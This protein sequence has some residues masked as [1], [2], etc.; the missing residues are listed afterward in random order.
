MK[1]IASGTNKE[2]GI[3]K[4]QLIGISPY[5]TELK[6][7]F[8]EWLQRLGY[9]KATIQHHHKSIA[10]FFQ[11]VTQKGIIKL[12]DITGEMI[13]EY[14]DFLEKQ[15]IGIKTFQAR[16]GSLRLFDQYLENYGHRPLITVRLKIIPDFR[17]PPNILTLQ[18]IKQ[19]YQATDNSK[20]GYKD[21]AMLAIYYGCGLRAQEGLN[22][23]L[24]DIDF[25]SGLLQVSK[26]KTRTPRYVPMSPAV[27]G[28][29]KDYLEAARPQLLKPDCGQGSVKS[30]HVLV[31]SRGRHKE[32]TGFNDRLKKLIEL[33][34]IEKQ[35]SLHGLRHSIATHLLENGMELEQIRQFLG[36]S[37]M[38]A[39]QRYTHVFYEASA[40]ENNV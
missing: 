27:M 20:S 24:R 34:G 1:K 26:T 17:I 22:L 39:T 5:F 40:K 16:L 35:V 7:G 4:A 37:S 13:L 38:Q 36:H 12:E 23:Q 30:D 31:H 19:I 11:L 15:P 10:L 14:Q 25:R 21:R 32:A 28:D 33:A 9:A 2:S 8:D 18:E 6:E 3:P 29:L